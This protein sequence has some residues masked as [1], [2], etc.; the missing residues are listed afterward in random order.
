MNIILFDKNVR[1][2][3]ASDERYEHLK[4]VLH[5]EVGTSFRGGEINSFS[6]ECT[7]TAV[8]KEK[9]EFDF[10]P[11][12]LDSTLYPLTV[13]LAQVRPICMKRI[14]RELVSLGVERLIL[15]RSDLGEKSYVESSLYTT[16]EY[17]TIMINGAMQAGHTGVS[18]AIFASSVEDALKEISLDTT[19]L[20]LDNVVGSQKFNQLSLKDKKVCI[21]IGPERGWSDR[22]RKC[23]LERGFIP[24]LM[25]NRILRTE[26][27]SVAATALALEHMN[28]I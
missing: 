24:V 7:I 28:Y 11:A 27:A 26:T 19:C 14:L 8:S 22:E 4:K 15:T 21:A 1:Q 18:D 6:G 17:K 9:I 25:G 12:K 2:F 5:A 23:L 13:L 10:L 16:N 3:N 20:L